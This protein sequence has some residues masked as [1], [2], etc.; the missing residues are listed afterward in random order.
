M[1]DTCPCYV[2]AAVLVTFLPTGSLRALSPAL[3]SGKAPEIGTLPTTHEH[4][5]KYSPSESMGL[6][7]SGK[8]KEAIGFL[9]FP[10][11]F[12]VAFPCKPQEKVLVCSV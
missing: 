7:L 4:S 6:I 1:Q 11:S 3:T 5:Q 2:S 9:P 12:N 8:Q 10:P